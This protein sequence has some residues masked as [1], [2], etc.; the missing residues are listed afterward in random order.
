MLDNARGHWQ[1]NSMGTTVS[2]KQNSQVVKGTAILKGADDHLGSGRSESVGSG[3]CEDGIKGSSDIDKEIST[4]AI[5]Q[6]VFG[7]CGPRD[8]EVVYTRHTKV[9]DKTTGLLTHTLPSLSL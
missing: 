5:E 6:R 3:H 1:S 4:N 7:L 9:K 8:V 2:Q